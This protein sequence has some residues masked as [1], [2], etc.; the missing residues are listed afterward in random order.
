MKL[1]PRAEQAA[2]LSI[3]LRMLG[4]AVQN[5][6]PLPKSPKTMDRAA[7]VR[8]MKALIQSIKS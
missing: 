7:A 5:A 3:W 1:C 6:T 8:N 4:L 2:N